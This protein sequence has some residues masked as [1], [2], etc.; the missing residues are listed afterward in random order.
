MAGIL[1]KKTRILDTT[2]TNVGRAQVPFG[3]LR[4]EY[5]TFTDRHADYAVTGSMTGTMGVASDISDR[6]YFEAPSA[7]NQDQICLEV[8]E[9]GAFIMSGPWMAKNAGGETKSNIETGAPFINEDGNVI[10][11]GEF[12][13]GIDLG[14]TGSILAAQS[15][16]N[17]R[18]LMVI[19]NKNS[20]F[21]G[22]TFEISTDVLQFDVTDALMRKH[23]GW[24]PAIPGQVEGKKNTQSLYPLHLDQRFRSVPN[25][26]FL[27]PINKLT[28]GVTLPRV[29]P[30][31]LIGA[32]I[33][34]IANAQQFPIEDMKVSILDT[35][36]FRESTPPAPEPPWMSMGW[37]TA[38]DD[39]RP[40]QSRVEVDE[41]NEVDVAAAAK[42]V[43]RPGG[44][45]YGYIHSLISTTGVGDAFSQ[46]SEG[47]NS[48]LGEKVIIKETSYDNNLF[49][50]VFEESEYG[51][52]A[53]Q[54]GFKKLSIIDYGWFEDEDPTKLGKR[55][56]FAGKMYFD[57]GQ[58]MLKF[59]NIFTVIF[60]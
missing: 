58:N 35:P 20:V 57:K 40:L 47:L 2:I 25:F 50:Q 5:A 31:T 44:R 53:P 29:Y 16:L 10:L 45:Q 7:R 18:D 28:P 34:G 37:P 22:N 1:D 49:I 54:G 59:A 30:F 52:A 38:F 27:P 21:S 4:F 33:S 48:A 41:L 8:A 24:E 55:V 23:T 42:C 56:F 36:E 13:K 26:M 60:K 6:V 15:K 32:N 17:F 39:M 3:R 46:L 19:N 11:D 14:I 43:M 12:A 51:G 9:E